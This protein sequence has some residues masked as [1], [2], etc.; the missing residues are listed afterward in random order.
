MASLSQ[1]FPAPIEQLP[2]LEPE[3]LAG[4]LMEFFNSRE[5]RPG[6]QDYHSYCNR[7]NFVLGLR[8]TL[9]EQLVLRVIEA[10]VWPQHEGFLVPSPEHPDQ[11]VVVSRRGRRYSTKPSMDAPRRANFLPRGSLHPAIADKVW[12]SFLRGD[13]ETAIFA[14]FKEVKIAVRTASQPPNEL[15]G[16]EL[17][18]KAFKPET[19]PLADPSAPKGEQEGVVNLFAGSMGYYRNSFGHRRVAITDP[20]EATKLI[21]IASHLLRLVDLRDVRT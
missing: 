21:V 4:Y 20:I 10:Y 13:Y 12:P 6:T 1:F 18:R 3:E 15:V 7:P 16:P 9:P 2:D 14:A 19:G 11:C 8:R 5:D 17:M